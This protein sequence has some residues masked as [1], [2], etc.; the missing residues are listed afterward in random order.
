MARIRYKLTPALPVN[1]T[2]WASLGIYDGKFTVVVWV[3]EPVYT[4]NGY[5]GG[6]FFAHYWLDQWSDT[7]PE[8]WRELIRFGGG[9]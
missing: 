5:V 8:S 9:R 6:E 4:A 1:Q 7:A 2:Y 3:T